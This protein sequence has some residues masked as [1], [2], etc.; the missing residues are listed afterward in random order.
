MKTKL[1]FAQHGA[2]M[3]AAVIAHAI[4]IILV[5]IPSFGFLVS[6]DF[7]LTEAVYFAVIIHAI[8]GAAA[9]VLGLWLVVAWRFRKDVKGCFPRKKFMAVTL[10]LWLIALIL[11]I[12]LYAV[13]YGPL[14]FG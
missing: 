14:L 5:M 13:F 6:P 3:A 8:S 1:K 11:G 4:S 12:V 7:I 9:F 10:T 2:V